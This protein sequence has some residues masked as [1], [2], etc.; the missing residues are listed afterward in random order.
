RR[1]ANSAL[2]ARCARGILSDVAWN[3]PRPRQQGTSTVHQ[4]LRLRAG[5]VPRSAGYAATRG[6]GE[7]GGAVAGGRGG[8]RRLGRQ[9]PAEPFAR[10][11]C[12]LLE[13]AGLLEEVGCAGYDHQ[14]L[15]AD[16]RIESLSVEIDDDVVGPADDQQ[17][18]LRNPG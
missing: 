14:L 16:Q 2:G 17:R 6:G 12:D 13:G 8:C 11:R 1:P 9:K 18:R 3:D 15:G 10:E 4:V 7:R 5:S